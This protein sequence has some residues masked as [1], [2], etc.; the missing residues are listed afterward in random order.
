VEVGIR[1]PCWLLVEQRGWTGFEV[2]VPWDERHYLSF[3]LGVV[4]ARGWD[5]L[6]FRLKYR[7]WLRWVYHGLFNAQDQWMVDLMQIPPERLYRPDVSVTAWR[8]LC[9]EKARG[10]AASPRLE[11][12]SLGA[13]SELGPAPVRAS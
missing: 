11:T 13:T 4:R 2:Y 3:L 5:A 10:P 6:R 7:L 8:K 1:L 9:Q 12:P